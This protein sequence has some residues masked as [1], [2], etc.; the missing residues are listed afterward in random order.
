[1][2]FSRVGLVRMPRGMKSV[3]ENKVP[4]GPEQGDTTE[5]GRKGPSRGVSHVSPHPTNRRTRGCKAVRPAG[6][7]I[8]GAARCQEE[9]TQPGG[10]RVLMLIKAAPRPASLQLVDG[11]HVVAGFKLRIVDLLAGD[12]QPPGVQLFLG[13]GVVAR[14]L[15]LQLGR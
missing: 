9:A 8:P 12:E 2:G 11:G 7:F 10:T 6:D 13:H 15:V 5:E 3:A 4:A 1:P 14:D